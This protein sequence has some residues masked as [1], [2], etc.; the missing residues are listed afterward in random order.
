MC[1]HKVLKN[2]MQVSVPLHVHIL[3]A[4]CFLSVHTGCENRASMNLQ[5]S[6]GLA[7]GLQGCEMVG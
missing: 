7:H 5:I 6:L 2:D 1:L 3:F 4:S